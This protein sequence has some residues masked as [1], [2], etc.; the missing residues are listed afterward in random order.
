MQLPELEVRVESDWLFYLFILKVHPDNLLHVGQ[1]KVGTDADV[2]METEKE[3][4]VDY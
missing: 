3:D 2:T 4:E 1:R